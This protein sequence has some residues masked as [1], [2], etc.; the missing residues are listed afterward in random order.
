M[1]SKMTTTR[2]S[3]LTG[4]AAIAAVPLAA[5]LP[6]FAAATATGQGAT[7]IARLWAQAESLTAQMA[8]HAAGIAANTAR[9][10]L[11]GWMHYRGDVNALGN[12]RYETIVGILNGKPQNQNDLVIVAKAIADADIQLGPKS[13]AHARFDQAARDYHMAA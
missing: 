2:R 1:T 8:P 3:V 13:W 5:A 11:P 7:P 10:G 12:R 4:G 9:T 6:A